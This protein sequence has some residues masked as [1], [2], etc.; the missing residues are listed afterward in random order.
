MNIFPGPQVL[1]DAA[2]LCASKRHCFFLLFPPTFLL[3]AGQ[4]PIPKLHHPDNAPW[5]LFQSSC[6]FTWRQIES[7][8]PRRPVWSNPSGCNITEQGQRTLPWAVGAGGVQHRSNGWTKDVFQLPPTWPGA[9]SSHRIKASC[10]VLCLQ[11]ILPPASPL[12]HLL[13]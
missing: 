8:A 11:L 12:P 9:S 4:E 5:V 10:L 2:K 3:L 1:P 6:H 13:R 7:H